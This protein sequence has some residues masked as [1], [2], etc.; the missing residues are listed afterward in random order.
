[1][2]HHDSLIIYIHHDGSRVSAV[3]YMEAGSSRKRLSVDNSEITSI[4]SLSIDEMNCIAD[5]LNGIDV[6]HLSK[7][8]KI[9]VGL[10][11]YRPRWSSLLI[12]P[13]D[14]L[15]EWKKILYKYNKI[16]RY[17]TISGPTYCPLKDFLEFIATINKDLIL[18]KYIHSYNHFFFTNSNCPVIETEFPSHHCVW[19]TQSSIQNHFQKRGDS[20]KQKYCFLHGHPNFEY[21]R[22]QFEFYI[23]A[24]KYSDIVLEILAN[25]VMIGTMRFYTSKESGYYKVNDVTRLIPSIFNNEDH[26]MILSIVFKTDLEEKSYLSMP[27][28]GLLYFYNKSSQMNIYEHVLTNFECQRSCTRCPKR[29]QSV[30]TFN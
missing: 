29:R 28:I 1:M 4:A 14:D 6:Y 20:V 12:H 16:I 24:P 9:F 2:D 10:Q 26:S 11:Y 23:Y 25:K 15:E 3:R 30:Q 18:I 8:S 7:C 22:Y 19:N 27:K 21:I 17:I 13:T 5:Y